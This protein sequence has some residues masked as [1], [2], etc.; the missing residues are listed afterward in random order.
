MF[1]DWYF[2]QGNVTILCL[3]TPTDFNYK[4]QQI[5]IL[6]DLYKIIKLFNSSSLGWLVLVQVNI[7]HI[8][9]QTFMNN[10]SGPTYRLQR[11]E[12]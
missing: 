5:T 12:C 4:Y 2:F 7:C 11:P 8:F 1:I 6:H 9:Y 10:A 3:F